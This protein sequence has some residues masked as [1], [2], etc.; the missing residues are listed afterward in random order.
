MGSQRVWAPICKLGRAA[1]WRLGVW[2]LLCRLLK[3]DPVACVGDQR[4]WAPMSPDSVGSGALK[5][6]DGVLTKGA[7]SCRWVRACCQASAWVRA[8]HQA[9]A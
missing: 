3:C 8:W 9:A 5:R 1:V 7:R 6:A 2:L 4:V